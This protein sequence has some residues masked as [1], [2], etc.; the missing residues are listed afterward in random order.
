MMVNHL[1]WYTAKSDQVTDTL[2][3]AQSMRAAARLSRPKKVSHARCAA[4]PSSRPFCRA[5]PASAVRTTPT[6]TATGGRA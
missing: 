2:N 6:A 5:S 4:P 1:P 3:A